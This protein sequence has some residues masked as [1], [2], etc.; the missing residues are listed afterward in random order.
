MK[1]KILF[2]CTGNSCR[3]QMAEGWA[4]QL[5]GDKIDAYSAG[6]DPHGLNALAVKAMKERDVDISAHKSKSLSDFDSVDF[7]LVVTV[8]DKAASSC[9]VPSKGAR[10]LHVPFDDPPS[11]A[12][13]SRNEEEAMQ[14]YRRVRYEIE[15]FVET[16]P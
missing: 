2:L 13:T 7:D 10:V 4:R 8:C 15:Q 5:L 12:R 3:S 9:P 14:H 1:P 16:L 11:L 6:T